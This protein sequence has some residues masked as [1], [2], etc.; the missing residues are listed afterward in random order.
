[1]LDEDTLKDLLARKDLKAKQ[2]LILCLAADP[3]RPRSV[4]QL[5]ELA[6]GLG[7]REAKNWNLSDYLSKSKPSI[8]RG[9]DGWELTETGKKYVT[10]L[11][12]PLLPAVTPLVI[13]SLRN[14]L[15]TIVSDSC[16][17]FVEE[18]IK[19]FEAKL[20]RSS[21]VLSWVGAI[22]VLYDYVISHSLNAFNIEAFRRDAKWRTATSADDL[23]RMKEYEFLQVLA[24]ISILGKSV[25]DELEVCLKLRN[26][27]G[28]PNS[29]VVGE[30]K[31]SAHIETLI[32]NIF[33]KF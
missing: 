20:Y 24:A 25:K 4:S 16:R 11:T 23:A 12:G 29:L 27:C 8:V 31:A 18:A 32:Q 14:Q 22:A 19:A 2:K 17:L 3:I 13:S 6:I 15:P 21:I 5:R 7:L 26:G 10:E 33:S 1:M 28:H 30:H 9:K